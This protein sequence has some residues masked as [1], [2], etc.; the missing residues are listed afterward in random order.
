[1]E[2]FP[3]MKKS[4]APRLIAADFEV[5]FPNL[6]NKLYEKFPTITAKLYELGKRKKSKDKLLPSLFELINESEDASNLG[7]F[8]L[9]PYLL[10]VHT[11]RSSHKKWRLSHVEVRDNF[12]G[13]VSDDLHVE[14]ELKTRQSI[15]ESKKLT[16]QPYIL[17]VGPTLKNINR[18]IVVINDITYSFDTVLQA[19]DT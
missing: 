14:E 16:L 3:C 11:V 1:M 2:E 18:Y 5:A 10:N 17:A 19:V 15:K 13:I 12:I 4:Y 7:A 6:Q 8:L 9:I